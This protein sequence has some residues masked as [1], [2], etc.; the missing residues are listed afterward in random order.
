MPEVTLEGSAYLT[1]ERNGA[2]GRDLETD[3][4]DDDDDECTP[5]KW[6]VITN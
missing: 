4:D 1:L 5:M 3:D 6:I 2:G